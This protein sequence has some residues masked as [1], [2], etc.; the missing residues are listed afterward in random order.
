M[1][2]SSKIGAVTVGGVASLFARADRRRPMLIGVAPILRMRVDC[3]ARFAADAR[4]SA[5][6]IGA[7]ARGGT[8]PG[9]LI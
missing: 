7:V 9:P 4:E 5:A 1:S 8:A 2:P 6:Q 3:V